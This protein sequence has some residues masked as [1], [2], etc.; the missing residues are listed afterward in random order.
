LAPLN[1]GENLQLVQM[2][3]CYGEKIYEDLVM[4]KKFVFLIFLLLFFFLIQNLV[5]QAPGNVPSDDDVI[6]EEE[7]DID[8]GDIDTGD[9]DT[10]KGR[11]QGSSALSGTIISRYN[12]LSLGDDWIIKKLPFYNKPVEGLEG[13]TYPLFDLFGRNWGKGSKLGFFMGYKKKEGIP[14]IEDYVHKGRDTDELNFFTN[15][16]GLKTTIV[17]QA[18][19]KIFAGIGKNKFLGYAGEGLFFESSPFSIN[20]PNLLGIKFSMDL[21]KKIQVDIFAT[22]LFHLDSSGHIWY[23]SI[24]DVNANIATDHLGLMGRVNLPFHDTTWLK[25]LAITAGGFQKK[26][27]WDF[28]Q[29]NEKD[30]IRVNYLGLSNVTYTNSQ[31]ILGVDNEFEIANHF[32]FTEINYFQNN[33]GIPDTNNLTFNKKKKKSGL[34]YLGFENNGYSLGPMELKYA[35]N[36]WFMDKKYRPDFVHQNDDNKNFILDSFDPFQTSPFWA[37]NN[38]RT[39]EPMSAIWGAGLN[40]VY[41]NIPDFIEDFILYEKDKFFS[42]PLLFE[43][44]DNNGV[45]DYLEMDPVKSWPLEVKPGGG[46]AIVVLSLQFKDYIKLTSFYKDQKFNQLNLSNDILGRS[47]LERNIGGAI[48]S[49]IKIPV[50][51]GELK[52]R[53]EAVFDKVD[54]NMHD[55]F[56]VQDTGNLIDDELL[57]GNSFN[58]KLR[59]ETL[60]KINLL[61]VE[62]KFRLDNY[63]IKTEFSNYIFNVS[64]WYEHMFIAKSRLN[65]KFRN[66]VYYFTPEIKIEIEGYNLAGQNYSNITSPHLLG[67]VDNRFAFHAILKNR[68][69]INPGFNYMYGLHYRLEY[70]E[71]NKVQQYQRIAIGNDLLFTGD[72]LWKA[73]VWNTLYF[74]MGGT[75]S[76]TQNKGSNKW[77]KGIDL[78]GSINI[79]FK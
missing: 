33:Y 59:T 41:N 45:I 4:I 12:H 26:G 24:R 76:L 78:Y 67:L 36:V 10:E 77:R 17:W 44:L 52:I 74:R 55:P 53:V 37:F 40:E 25:H 42:G 20:L 54:D 18:N 79:M 47:P 16:G 35:I 49:G 50:G 2:L 65:F 56:Y 60:F 5:A 29:K 39:E 38:I 32:L 6:E 72:Q 46:G 71:K 14:F 62:V 69:D 13:K 9:I 48:E 63:S 68:L 30:N 15:Q 66:D 23:R 57:F 61:E 8:T 3:H 21:A 58:T 34:A 43:D 19:Y 28:N 1:G 31:W 11:S 75:F 27:G 51:S 64:P 7:E 70:S 73:D 22:T